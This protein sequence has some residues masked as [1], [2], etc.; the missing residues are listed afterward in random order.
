M[1]DL[2]HKI[3]NSVNCLKFWWISPRAPGPFA[4]R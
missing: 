4:W 2:Y 1:R 3:C